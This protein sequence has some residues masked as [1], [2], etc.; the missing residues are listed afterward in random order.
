MT[1]LMC[2]LNGKDA[3]NSNQMCQVWTNQQWDFPDGR[4]IQICP[5][6]S[7]IT[8]VASSSF[9]FIAFYDASNAL[10]NLTMSLQ[11]HSSI[12]RSVQNSIWMLI[13]FV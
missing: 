11:S 10:V 5:Q 9:S 8:T 12:N 3:V 4:L 13:K 1:S 6:I 7:A 2:S